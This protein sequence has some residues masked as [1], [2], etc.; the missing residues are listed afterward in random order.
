VGRLLRTHVGKHHVELHDYVIPTFR[1]WTRCTPSDSPPTAPSD[2]KPSGGHC[3]DAH[4]PSPTKAESTMPADDALDELSAHDAVA[5]FV[6]CARVQHVGAPPGG[7]STRGSARGAPKKTEWCSDAGRAR[8]HR[9]GHRG[10][11]SCRAD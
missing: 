1:S 5:T 3:A 6:S 4:P 2:S 8:S 10:T 9:R 7:W 11:S